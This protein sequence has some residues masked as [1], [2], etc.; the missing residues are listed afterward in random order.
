VAVPLRKLR[1]K[2]KIWDSPKFLFQASHDFLKPGIRFRSTIHFSD[3]ALHHVSKTFEGFFDIG[4]I[5]FFY[6][7]SGSKNRESPENE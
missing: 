1:L 4:I 5:D 3:K 6:G 7:L 2:L